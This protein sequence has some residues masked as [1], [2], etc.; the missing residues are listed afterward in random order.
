[1]KIYFIVILILAEISICSAAP[2]ATWPSCYEIGVDFDG[3]DVISGLRF[4]EDECANWCTK[5]GSR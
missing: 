4:S 1:M 3:D 2:N 5:V